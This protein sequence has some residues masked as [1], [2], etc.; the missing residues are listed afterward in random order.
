MS[1]SSI[2]YDKK[3]KVTLKTIEMSL[4][5]TKITG[6]PNYSKPHFLM[7]TTRVPGGPLPLSEESRPAGSSPRA[8]SSG[9]ST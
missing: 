7:P 5:L 6:V 4:A 1:I 2:Y 8:P 3:V 9:L